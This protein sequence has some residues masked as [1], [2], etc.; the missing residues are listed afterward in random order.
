LN[1]LLGKIDFSESNKTLLIAI[2]VITALA[3]LFT[4][5]FTNSNDASLKENSSYISIQTLASLPNDGIPSSL[6]TANSL[7]L[8]SESDSGTGSNSSTNLSVNGKQITVPANG[9]VSKTISN[10]DGTTVKISA[11]NTQS[12]TSSNNAS[13]SSNSLEV[14]S[15]SVDSSSSDSN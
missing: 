14:N 13:A 5:Y 3:L 9:S 2:S 10:G 6:T 8:L 12:S 7:P 11:T 15:E 4:Y 1:N